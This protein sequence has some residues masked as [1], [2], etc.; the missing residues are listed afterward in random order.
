MQQQEPSAKTGVAHKATVEIKG[1]NKGF[2]EEW[3]REEV[4]A[5]FNLTIEP[6]QLTMVVGPSG[7]GKSTLVN[8]VAGFEVPDSG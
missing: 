2:G 3:Q 1:V 4:I 5:N 7:C 6:G 8:L